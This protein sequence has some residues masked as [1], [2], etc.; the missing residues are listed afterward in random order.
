[1][2]PEHHHED[3][4]Y[5]NSSAAVEADETFGVP[6]GKTAN[7][8]H[9]CNLDC[10]ATAMELPHI[11]REELFTLIVGLEHLRDDYEAEA[12]RDRSS[13]IDQT[14]A[15]EDAAKWKAESIQAE[16]LRQR[17]KDTPNYRPEKV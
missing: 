17:L 13:W 11:S 14:F 12:R 7:E 16:Q 1:M 3:C 6:E 10:E 15:S 2:K 5:R 8:V 9:D 4:D